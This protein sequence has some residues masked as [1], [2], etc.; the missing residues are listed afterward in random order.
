MKGD[1]QAESG[2]WF[3]KSTSIEKVES[4]SGGFPKTLVNYTFHDAD[5]QVLVVERDELRSLVNSGDWS[6][7]EPSEHC[8]DCP[9]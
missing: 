7:I 2:T 4:G 8:S 1:Y 6:L 3:Y 9:S 5:G